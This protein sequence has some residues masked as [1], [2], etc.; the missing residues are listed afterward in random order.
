MCVEL[1]VDGEMQRGLLPG[2]L[3]LSA[4]FLPT[5][6]E[7]SAQKGC[8]ICLGGMPFANPGFGGQVARKSLEGSVTSV[9]KLTGTLQQQA[10]HIREGAP[11]A[12]DSSSSSSTMF[13]SSP[14][15]LRQRGM[16]ANGRV[17]Q[18]L[19]DLS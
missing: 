4:K 2:L 10:H 14:N 1:D 9:Q 5:I 8:F 16:P 18:E 7:V 13:E 17:E 12:Q 15:S 6:R 11:T 19:A 3:A